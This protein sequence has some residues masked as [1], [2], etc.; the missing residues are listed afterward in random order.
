MHAARRVDKE[1]SK[2]TM[3]ISAL[4]RNFWTAFFLSS[5][6]GSSRGEKVVGWPGRAEGER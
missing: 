3:E 2:R 4:A 6:S 5:R 1:Q